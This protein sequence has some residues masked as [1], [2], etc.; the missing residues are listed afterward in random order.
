MKLPAL[1]LALAAS[2]ASGVAAAPAV[3]TRVGPEGGGVSAFLVPP[4]RPATAYAGFLDGGI[5]RTDDRGLS[6]RYAGRG[7]GT[8]HIGG[9]AVD[10]GSAQTL[11]AVSGS[12]GIVKTVDGG[13][14]WRAAAHG[15]PLGVTV[16]IVAVA[17][18]GRR[19]GRVYAAA[20]GAEIYRSSDGA[21]S[22]NPLPAGAPRD[23]IALIADPRAADRL[24]AV[25]ATRQLWRSEDAGS[26][27]R[28]VPKVAGAGEQV[29]ALQIDPQRSDVLYASVYDGEVTHLR[30]SLDRGATWAL[31]GDLSA[32]EVRSF[33]IDPAHPQRLYLGTDGGLRRSDDGGKTWA[34]TADA[35]GGTQFHLYALGDAVLAQPL[36]GTFWRSANRGATWAAVHGIRALS[37]RQLATAPG[38]RVFALA[39]VP[40]A[41]EAFRSD[42][43]GVT[44]HALAPLDDK[45]FRRFGNL[46]ELDPS[47]PTTV[48][49]GFT[50]TLARSEDGG[51]H[52]AAIASPPCIYPGELAIDPTDSGNLYLSGDPRPAA[53]CPASGPARCATY[54]KLG[55]APWECINAELPGLGVPVAAVDP[56]DGN[57]LYAI[58]PYVVLRSPDRGTHWSIVSGI[59]YLR[60]IAT[61]PA[62]P[63][64]LY[65]GY[66]GG[67]ARSDDSAATWDLTHTGLPGEYVNRI[68]P[69]PV[70]TG[71]VYATTFNE[72][73]RSDDSGAHWRRV[74]PGLEECIVNDLAIDPNDPTRLYVATFGGGV[75]RVK[76]RN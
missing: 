1:V 5:Y 65:A 46:F 18:D 8:S 19:A 34:P 49:A 67:V 74:A 22:W 48:Y 53:G 38:G 45:P 10:A 11:Y 71:R 72:V 24:Y 15:L 63:G 28:R 70:H 26:H 42:D 50:E 7:S 13:A 9:L 27:W 57:V 44:W 73:F 62:R 40:S 41:G 47:A 75:L 6:W 21:A 4:G 52:F 37:M 55:A 29:L 2:V 25:S 35:P 33:A 59:D 60:T 58:V 61:D 23:V 3:W 12:L 56:F 31:F 14:S 36:D 66:L 51:D 54:R 30:R 69:D 20:R 68:V 39:G 64:V 76:Q 17:A 32:G 43:R 16:P